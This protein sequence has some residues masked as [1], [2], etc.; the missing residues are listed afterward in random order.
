MGNPRRKAKHPGE[1]RNFTGSSFLQRVFIFVLIAAFSFTLNS[2]YKPFYTYYNFPYGTKS[3]SMGNA[4]VGIAD[5]LT[6]VFCNPA[7]ITIF[8]TPS[9]YASYKTDSIHY[10]YELQEKDFG[11]YS[12]EYNHN[13]VTRL[14]NINCLSIVAPVVFRQVKWNFALSYYRCIPY[15]HK[16]YSQGTLTTLARGKDT[17]R[18]TVNFSGSSG[19]DVLGFTTAFHLMK[20]FAFGVTLQQFFNSGIITYDGA[21]AAPGCDSSTRTEKLEGRNLIFGILFKIYK[22]INIGFAYH[23]RLTGTFDSQLQCREDNG[24]PQEFSTI[25]DIFIP[26]K[27]SLGTCI[28]LLPTLNLSYEFSRV[29]WS[30]GKIGELPFPVRG[31]F[32][33]NQADIIN[34]RL[35]VDYGLPLKKVSLFFRTGISWDRQLFRGADSANV[36]A[37]G[38]SLGCGVFFLPGFLIELAFMHQRA[39]WQEAGY[40]DPQSF[41]NTTYKNNTLSLALTYHFGIKK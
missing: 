5:D 20:D 28:R 34:H 25:S 23:T 41:V 6:A 26:E 39:R 40:F 22:D 35:G 19:I 31:N 18:T 11:T 3:L 2:R 37:R 8:Q 13:F 30:K 32:S 33:F 10:D 27:F 12:Q 24:G 36:T 9:V 7:G 15:G 29:Y 21:G 4:F 17:E 14:K 1:R 38:Y 16:G